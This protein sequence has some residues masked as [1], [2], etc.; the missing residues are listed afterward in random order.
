MLML[1]YTCSIYYFLAD[2][3]ILLKI[4][5]YNPRF[6]YFQSKEWKEKNRLKQQKPKL[7]IKIV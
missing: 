7:E 5:V 4:N 1:K 3:H 6:R 2:G